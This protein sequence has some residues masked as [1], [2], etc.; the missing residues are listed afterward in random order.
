MTVRVGHTDSTKVLAIALARPA[1]TKLTVYLALSLP[2]A[3][4]HIDDRKPTD[5]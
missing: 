2:A 5:D 3:K 4:C 1:D